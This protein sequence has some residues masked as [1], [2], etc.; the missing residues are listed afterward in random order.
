MLESKN[1]WKPYM[2]VDIHLDKNGQP[3]VSNRTAEGTQLLVQTLFWG[4]DIQ[5]PSLPGERCPTRRALSEQVMEPSWIQDPSETSLFR[6]R[7]RLQ[8]Q[9]SFWDT[10]LFK[11]QTSRHLPRQRRGVCSR[12][13]WPPEQVRQ[14]SCVPCPSETNLCRWACRLQRQQIFWD[15]PC[16]GPSLSARR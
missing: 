2:L 13:L 5:A 10:P 14:P 8:K 1:Q 6:W 3:R 16:F 7:C 4:P 15:R 12:G 11:L 9:H